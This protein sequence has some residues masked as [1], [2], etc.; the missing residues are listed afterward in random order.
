MARS[1]YSPRSSEAKV[2]R[3]EV[4]DLHVS[5]EDSVGGECALIGV[6]SVR[7]MVAMLARYASK[8]SVRAIDLNIDSSL[9][10]VGAALAIVAAVTGRAFIGINPDEERDRN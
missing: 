3:I 10:W 7:P 9:L 1:D 6:V 2:F 5:K 8:F 4:S